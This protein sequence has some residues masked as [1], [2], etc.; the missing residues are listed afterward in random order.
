MPPVVWAYLPGIFLLLLASAFFSGSE[1]AFFSLKV[2]QR[3]RL[4]KGIAAARL[5]EQLAKRS[6]RRLMG[7]LFWNLAINIAYFSL[8]SKLA[9]VLEQQQA[10]S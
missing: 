4:A 3:A 8:V 1:A 7:I 10:S 6:E 5:A 2:S 9:L